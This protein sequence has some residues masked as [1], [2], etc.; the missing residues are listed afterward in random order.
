VNATGGTGDAAGAE[1]AAGLSEGDGD[2]TV[3]EGC[4]FVPAMPG[5]NTGECGWVPAV[6]TVS[7]C[8]GRGTCV[9]TAATAT[10][11]ASTMYPIIN[12]PGFKAAR[13]AAIRRWYVATGIAALLV[14]GVGQPA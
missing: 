8:R 14:D 5:A 2:G 12:S 6:N 10:A 4:S 1:L 3:E 7:V 9:V 13:M 11:V